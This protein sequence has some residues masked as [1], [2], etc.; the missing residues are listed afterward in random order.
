MFRRVAA[1]TS[2]IVFVVVVAVVT[3]CELPFNGA[4]THGLTMNLLVVPF[5]IGAWRVRRAYGVYCV[6]L[7]KSD[8]TFVESP[9]VDRVAC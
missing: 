4:F 1:I 3:L 6:E 7:V 9:P 5:Q 8:L 2:I